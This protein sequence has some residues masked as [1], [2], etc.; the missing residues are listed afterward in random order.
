MKETRPFPFLAIIALTGAVGVLI[1]THWGVGYFADSK[2]YLNAARNL[3]DVH[4][5]V[6][7][8]ASGDRVPL[9]TWP[10]LFPALLAL[11]GLI[12]IDFSDGDRW[13]NALAFCAN[14]SLVG[15]IIYRCTRSRWTS[16]IGSFLML[17]T[18][19]MLRIHT[20]AGTEPLFLFLFLIGLFLLGRYL[21]TSRGWYLLSSSFAVALAS[22]ARY[23]GI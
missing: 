5:L 18:L 10:P 23:P 3:L 7:T 21:E 6:I 22:L 9:A 11:I 13:L 12:G 19:D 14:I 8:T 20:F 17:T 1:A 4:E 2:Y 15:L 16:M